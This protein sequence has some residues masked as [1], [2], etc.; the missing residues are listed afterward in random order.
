MIVRPMELNDLD[1]I[2]VLEN[3]LYKK[4]WNKNQFKYEIEE[5]EFSYSFILEDDGTLIGYYIFWKLFENANITKVSIAREFQG[6]GLANILLLDCLKRIKL[7]ECEVVDLE[8]RV[9]NFKAVNLYKK[10][11]F[12]QTHVRKGYYED[13]EDALILEKKIGDETNE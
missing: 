7:L 1:K 9:S 4:P 8:V 3:D 5:N 11:E 2:I 6:R 12:I 10:H 13:G